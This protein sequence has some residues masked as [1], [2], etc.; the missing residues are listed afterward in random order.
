MLESLSDSMGAWRFMDVLGKPAMKLPDGL[1]QDLLTWRWLAGVVR[2]QN[3][4][5][6]EGKDPFAVAQ[7][8]SVKDLR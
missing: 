5:I 7:P 6:E 4:M 2:K 3:Q 1:L 8:L